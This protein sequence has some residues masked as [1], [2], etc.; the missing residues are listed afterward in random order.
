M[1]SDEDEIRAVV[2][3]YVEGMV[4]ADADRMRRAFHSRACIVG[5]FQGELEWSTLDEFIAA[6]VAEGAG[7]GPPQWTLHRI[8]VEGDAGSAKLEDTFAGMRFVDYLSLL[9]TADGWKIVNKL[10]H[11]AG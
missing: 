2:T 8:D 9:N 11:H 10:Y 4:G 7:G 6:V 5:N 1:G 3:E